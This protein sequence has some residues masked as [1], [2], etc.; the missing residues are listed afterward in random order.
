[1]YHRS[2]LAACLLS[3]SDQS[4]CFRVRDGRGVAAIKRSSGPFEVSNAQFTRIVQGAFVASDVFDYRTA[5]EPRGGFGEG[6]NEVYFWVSSKF[7]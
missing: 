6:E 3:G 1:M 5:P 7:F 2:F 4:I